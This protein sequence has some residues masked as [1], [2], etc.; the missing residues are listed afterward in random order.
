M[1][2]VDL[3]F[4]IRPHFRWKVAPQL[5]ASHAEGHPLQSTLLTIGCHAYT[6]VDA[7]LHFLVDG[8]DIASMPVDQWSVTRA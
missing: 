2:V 7:P 1:R 8:R 3:S 6:H 4:S 5:V